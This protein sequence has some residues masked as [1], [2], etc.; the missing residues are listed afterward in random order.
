M[1]ATTAQLSYTLRELRRAVADRFGDY[2]Q[3]KATS[4]GSTTTVID[5][6]NVNAGAEHFNGRQIQVVSGTYADHKARVTSTADSTGTLTFTPAAGGAIASGVLVDVY[7]RRGTG[8]Q[9]QEYDRAINNA[10][11]DAFPLGLIDTI[12]TLSTGITRNDY[13]TTIT[14]PAK[15]YEVYAIEW[16]DDEDVWREV[17]K[18]TKTNSYGWKAR[19]DGV[20]E[21]VGLPQDNT[22]E[23]TL[24]IRGYARQD[25]LSADT[26][27]CGLPKE[28]IVARAAY[29]LALGAVMRGQEY[30][31]LA[32]QFAREA[33]MMRTRLR[34]LR[35]P[36]SERVRS[37]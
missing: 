8:F 37:Y 30:G 9:I 24:R 7:N 25:A 19:P 6:L 15:F 27:T 31:A 23:S 21:I 10:I 20:I 35:R 18:A 33:E 28:W 14:V 22:E 32:Q 11:G 3:L 4:G 12:E 13:I 29:Y 26:D 2:L 34:T 17:I 36:S 1:T 5:A 16:E